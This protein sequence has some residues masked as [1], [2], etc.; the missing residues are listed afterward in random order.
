MGSGI[1]QVCAMAGFDTVVRE[2]SDAVIE[3]SRSGI[4]KVLAKGIEKGKVTAEQRDAALSKLSFGTDLAHLVMP[5]TNNDV[6]RNHVD[7]P[8]RAVLRCFP[9][10]QFVLLSI[11]Q[12]VAPHQHLDV[13]LANEIVVKLVDSFCKQHCRILSPRRWRLL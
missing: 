8:G 4:D 1:A 6:F 11:D 10:A 3:K 13:M 12:P 7:S 2:I 9:L 5:G